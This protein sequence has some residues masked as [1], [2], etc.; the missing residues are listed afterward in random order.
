MPPVERPYS[1]MYPAVMTLTSPRNS[2]DIGTDKVPCVGL[3]AETPSMR[4]EFSGELA[5]L[6]DVPNRSALAPGATAATDSNDLEPAPFPVGGEIG[7]RLN[8]SFVILMPT[9]VDPTSTVGAC[10]CTTTSSL[11]ASG[12]ICA[13]KRIVASARSASPSRW[14]SLND[15]FSA[16]ST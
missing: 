8:V 1:G 15:S 5:P 13:S 14:K 12:S 4:Y 2:Y 7:T 10:A 16:R 3:L 9:L 6:I 11:I